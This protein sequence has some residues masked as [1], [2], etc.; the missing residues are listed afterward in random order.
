VASVTSS[1]LYPEPCGSNP[2]SRSASEYRPKYLFIVFSPIFFSRFKSA[3]VGILPNSSA[4]SRMALIISSLVVMVFGSNRKSHPSGGSLSLHKLWIEYRT[5]RGS[6]FQLSILAIPAILAILNTA[7]PREWRPH[8]DLK[9][10]VL[11]VLELH[12]RASCRM[13]GSPPRTCRCA[14]NRVVL[15]AIPTT[16]AGVQ[17]FERPTPE[18]LPACGNLQGTRTLQAE[19]LAILNFS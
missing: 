4:D 16:S 7:P 14:H 11:R 13:P 15:P 3:I 9:R 19:P 10:L 1:S 2:A 6:D 8:Q 12:L 18:P 5:S 17:A